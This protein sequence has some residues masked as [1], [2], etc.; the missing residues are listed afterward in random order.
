MS[1]QRDRAKDLR[2]SQTEAEEFVW[3]QLRSRRFAGF[4][5]RRQFPLGRYIVDFICLDRRVIVELDG[6]QHNEAH[7]RAYDTRRDAWL[8]RQGFEVLRFWNND[9]FLEWEAI[10]DGI[11][12]TLH[13]RPSRRDPADSIPLPRG[14][15]NA[16][17]R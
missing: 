4:K 17:R 3:S 11:W 14:E 1:K 6:G 12:C 5:F 7:H 16:K 15:R 10:A 2:Q 9:V 13:S 8:K